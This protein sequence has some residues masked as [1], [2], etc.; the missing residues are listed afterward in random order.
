MSFAKYQEFTRTTAIYPEALTGSVN[1][2]SYLA[3]GLTSEAGEVSGKVKKIMRDDAGQVSSEKRGD[4]IKEIG[5]VLWYLART[6]DE[7]GVNLGDI[8]DAN[9]AKLADRK[10]RGVLG[11]SGDNR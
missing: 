6:A 8:A 2:L 3:H 4:I 9:I 5:D 1:A 7:L 11:G 10:E